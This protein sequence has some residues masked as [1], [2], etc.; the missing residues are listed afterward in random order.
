MQHFDVLEAG[1]VVP[2]S[3][4]LQ[5]CHHAQQD[6][7]DEAPLVVPLS[8]LPSRIDLEHLLCK[9]KRGRAP[10][11]DHV[12]VDTLRVAASPS[13]ALLYQ[14]LLKSF[15]QGAE[16]LQ[17]KG[18]KLHVIPKKSNVLR[19]DAMRGIMLLTVYGK[20][21]HAMLRRMLLPWTTVSKLPTQLGGFLWAADQLCYP[22]FADL[23]S[24]CWSS[25]DVLRGP[26]HR[27]PCCIS[28]DDSRAHFWWNSLACSP[29]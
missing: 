18:G 29:L 6:A 23:L 26:V 16:P 27:R 10:G 7:L 4:L 19:A 13:S 5:N 11:I 12:T 24:P 9:A 22:P 20:L 25:S 3:D 17:W 8:D 14:L 21:Y 2:Y 15:L 28:L 1:E